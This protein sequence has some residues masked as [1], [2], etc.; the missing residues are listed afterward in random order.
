MLTEWEI[1]V[2]GF[3]NRINYMMNLLKIFN[4]MSFESEKA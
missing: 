2:T 4:R 1:P 3:Y